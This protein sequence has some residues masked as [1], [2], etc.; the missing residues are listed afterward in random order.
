MPPLRGHA[1][2]DIVD[3]E[4]GTAHRD[5]ADEWL[6]YDLEISREAGVS[7]HGIRDGARSTNN[8]V[9]RSDVARLTNTHETGPASRNQGAGARSRHV[10]GGIDATRPVWRDEVLVGTQFRGAVEDGAISLWR[11]PVL[12]SVAGDRCDTA[13]AEVE[14]RGGEAGGSEEGDEEGAEAAVDVE[15]DAA[16]DSELGERGDVVDD[17]VGE[18][19]GR[20]DEEDRVAVYEAR[21]R[22]DGDLVGGRGASDEVDLDSEVV[23]GFVEGGVRRVREDPRRG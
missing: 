10:G 19:G 8:L 5:D 23:A 15:W 13:E 16:R 12:V 2:G 22:R 21:D 9:S 6:A 4:G 11:K 20:A 14:E 1:V 18:V 3:V 17:A 7:A